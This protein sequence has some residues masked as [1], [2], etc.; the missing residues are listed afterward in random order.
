MQLINVDVI[1]RAPE[2]LELKDHRQIFYG[3]V[4]LADLLLGGTRW[5]AGSIDIELALVA[6]EASL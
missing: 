1:F 6:H 3:A 2:H 5:D 4:L